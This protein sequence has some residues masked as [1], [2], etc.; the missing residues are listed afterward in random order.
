M[1]NNTTT[2]GNIFT[3][4]KYTDQE[5]FAEKILYICSSI[6]LNAELLL[7]YLFNELI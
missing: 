5:Y 3:H 1:Y 4:G 6:I 7:Q 2:T